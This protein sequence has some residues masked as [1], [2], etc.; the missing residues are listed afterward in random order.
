MLGDEAQ[1]RTDRWHR[2]RTSRQPPCVPRIRRR[3]VPTQHRGDLFLG[4]PTL[5]QRRRHVVVDVQVMPVRRD[6]R[7]GLLRQP[8]DE[9]RCVIGR[10]PSCPAWPLLAHPH[11]CPPAPGSAEHVGARS[12]PMPVGAVGDQLLEVVRSVESP[13]DRSPRRQDESAY[14]LGEDALLFEGH[15]GYRRGCRISGAVRRCAWAT[16]QH[17]HRLVTPGSSVA[18]GSRHGR[19]CLSVMSRNNSNHRL[20]AVQHGARPRRKW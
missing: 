3:V 4:A 16:A 6:D 8:V 10:A 14:L 20:Q 18:R 13:G 17:A 15:A 12:G 9:T 19:I 11:R 7:H 1:L 2:R 5:T